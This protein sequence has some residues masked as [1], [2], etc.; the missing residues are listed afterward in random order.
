MLSLRPTPTGFEKSKLLQEK[1]Q[2]KEEVLN[3]TAKFTSFLKSNSKEQIKSVSSPE[4]QLE[5]DE[6]EIVE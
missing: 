6:I 1:T 3:K 4:P 2:K 5:V